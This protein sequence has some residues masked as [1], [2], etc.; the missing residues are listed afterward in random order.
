[1]KHDHLS[2]RWLPLV[3]LLATP[4]PSF[5][6]AKLYRYIDE[7]GVKVINSAIPPEHVKRGYEIVTVA[8]DVLEVVPPAM[9]EEEIRAKEKEAELEEWNERL[10]KRYTTVEDIEAAKQRK[11][12]EFAASMSILEGNA[13]NISA[14]IDNVQGRAA[15]IER[16]GRE[17]PAVIIDNLSALKTELKETERLIKLREAD[18]VEL[19]KRFDQDIEHFAKI[20]A[21]TDS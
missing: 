12:A 11:L 18:K 4:L 21:E 16:S 9:T 3:L 2:L 5:A 19:E 15:D 10:L 1:M 20:Q 8:G 6:Q 13:S 14:Q 17:V 7:N